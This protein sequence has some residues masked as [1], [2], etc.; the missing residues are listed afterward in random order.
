MET[1]ASIWLCISKPQNQLKSVFFH[2]LGSPEGSQSYKHWFELGFL[3]NHRGLVALICI[4]RWKLMFF[5]QKIKVERSPPRFVALGAPW[6]PQND[7][8]TTSKW[9]K[10]LISAGFFLANHRVMVT[11]RCITRWELMIFGQKSK[12]KRS[13]PRFIALGAFWRPLNDPKMT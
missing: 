2:I 10:T 3:T 1:T 13:P 12:V 9:E 11:L 6:R 8:K 4:T 7:P 5:G